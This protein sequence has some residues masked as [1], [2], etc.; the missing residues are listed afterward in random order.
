MFKLIKIIC[1]FLLCCFSIIVNAQSVIDLSRSDHRY[2]KYFNFSA[3]RVMTLNNLTSSGKK[4][5]KLKANVEISNNNFLD[6]LEWEQINDP[7]Y[8]PPPSYNRT[9]QFGNWIKDPTHETCYDTRHL[10][11]SEQSLIPIQL[12]PKNS[13]RIV[14]GRWYD[15]YSDEY[16]DLAND[17]Q[18]DHVVPLKN[19]YLAGAWEWSHAKRCHY[20]NFI[21]TKNH[22]LPVA[23]LENLT[24]SERGPEAYIPNNRSFQCQYLA[25][26]LHIKAVWQL[27]IAIV[28]GNAIQNFVHQNGCDKDL[29]I[30]KADELEEESNE[31]GVLPQECQ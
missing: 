29:F 8:T 16:Y 7:S 4:F 20:F 13:C 1:F 23:K 2:D 17:L 31:L 26:W 11:L 5:S 9:Q 6:L 19:A 15:P 28:E 22:L 30:L 18:I 27:K 24:K 25:L 10:I 14:G 12:D 3:L 21:K